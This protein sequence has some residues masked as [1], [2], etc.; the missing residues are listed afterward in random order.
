[1]TLPSPA[2]QIPLSTISP[3]ELAAYQRGRADYHAGLDAESARD[4]AGVNASAWAEGWLHEHSYSGA[5]RLRSAQP[6]APRGSRESAA[7]RAGQRGAAER[8]VHRRKVTDRVTLAANVVHRAYRML[9]AI[10][11]R[12]DKEPVRAEGIRDIH[13]H[14]GVLIARFSAGGITPA[15]VAAAGEAAGHAVALAS[16]VDRHERLDAFMRRDLRADLAALTETLE[17][18]EGTV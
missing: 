15:L 12:R 16:A 2:P 10:E 8:V 6:A 18:L 7:G 13:I 9:T 11:R 17:I 3:D 5:G 14:L 4:R 1:M